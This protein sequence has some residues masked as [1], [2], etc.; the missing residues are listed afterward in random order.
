MQPQT[1]G[2]VSLPEE[3]QGEFNSQERPA[4]DFHQADSPRLACGCRTKPCDSL[5]PAWAAF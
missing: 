4:S 1:N 3:E 5:S 2:H